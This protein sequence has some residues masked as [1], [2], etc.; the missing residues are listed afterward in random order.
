MKGNDPKRWNQLLEALDEKLQLN[1]LEHLR[2]IAAYHFEEDVLYLE[3]ATPEEEEFLKKDAV[4]QQLQLYA[5]D[6]LKVDKVKIKR[7]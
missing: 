5:I 6:I 2:R 1:L 3:P 4:L 7:P